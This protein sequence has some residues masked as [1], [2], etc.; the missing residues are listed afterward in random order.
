VCVVEGSGVM[1][2]VRL[3]CVIERHADGSLPADSTTAEL[4]SVAAVPA[5]L[6]FYDLPQFILMTF[7]YSPGESLASRGIHMTR[8]FETLSLL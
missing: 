2:S 3:H 8:Q 6:P 7:G 4:D 1:S 5:S